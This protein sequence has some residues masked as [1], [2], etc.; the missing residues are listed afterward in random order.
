[1]DVDWFKVTWISWL[2]LFIAWVVV[3]VMAAVCV[4]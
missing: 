1:M 2:V 3:F 4:F